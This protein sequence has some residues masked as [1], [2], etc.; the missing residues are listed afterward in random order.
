MNS[1]GKSSTPTLPP[2]GPVPLF[3]RARNTVT[4]THPFAVT[5]KRLMLMNMLVVSAIL[6]IMALSVYAWEVHASDQQVTEQLVHTV[7]PE[8]QSDL[9]ARVGDSI[10]A[11]DDDTSDEA[12]RYEPDSPNVF[13]IGLDQHAHVVFDPGNVRV[14]GLPDLSLAWPVLR[15]RQ[16][17][18]LVTI[19]DD[20]TAYRLY[21]VPVTTHG[22]I[23]GV[24]QVGQSLEARDRQLADLRIILLG[25]GAGV[26][27]LTGL[28]SLYLAGRALSP[29]QLAYERQRQFA[30]AASHELRTPLA[31]V[32]SQAELIERALQRVVS[33]HPVD[34]E[35]SRRLAVTTTDVADILIEVD[36]MARLVRDLLV[37]ARD[38]GDHRNIVSDLVD[39]SGLAAET[40]RK[41]MAQADS[42]GI[43]LVMETGHCDGTGGEPFPIYVRGDN[44]RIRQLIL[45]LLENAVH[46]TPRA[47]TV[48]VTL[49]VAS[50]RHFL[51]GH[52]QVAQL[53]VVD[54]GT[55]I[56]P[57]ALPHIFEPF[58]RASPD[59]NRHAGAGLGLAIAQ[60][61]VNAHGGKIA[62]ESEVG[63]GT[64]F[65]VSL[66]LAQSSSGQSHL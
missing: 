11:E 30:A 50:G 21:T 47:G 5:R 41:M 32:R 15:G 45:A 49:T 56:A 58:Y 59:T 35:E 37:L 44:G 23:V 20:A 40:T 64:E 8:L 13:V 46:Y 9:V 66:P 4:S 14:Q 17:S 53:I 1:A 51:V 65:T 43:S 62:V 52:R 55:G 26:L 36:Y 42:A 7:T 25:V 3:S 34:E 2:S 16:A 28:A 18:T 48:R 10:P 57:E 63:V 24:L 12:A 54:T 22:R 27:L 60:W 29:M 6:A 19:G 33:G 38:E 61:I 31:I 39:L